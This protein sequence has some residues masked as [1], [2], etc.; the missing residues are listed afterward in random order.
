MSPRVFVGRP[1]VGWVADNSLPRIGRLLEEPH[2]RRVFAVDVSRQRVMPL[3]AGPGRQVAGPS[4]AHVFDGA[5]H[6][7]HG[8]LLAFGNTNGRGQW[9]LVRV[10]ED[11][12]IEDTGVPTDI[13]V[14]SLCCTDDEDLLLGVASTEIAGGQQIGGGIARFSLRTKVLTWLYRP[15]SGE[16]FVPSGI[17][18]DSGD[19]IFT[20][21]SKHTL[22]RLTSEGHLERVLGRVGRPD[23]DVGSLNSPTGV[24]VSDG[25]YVLTDRGNHRVLLVDRAGDVVGL[26]GDAAKD[27]RL[28]DPRHALS[29][30]SRVYIADLG[31]RAVL[32]VSADLRTTRERWGGPEAAGLVLSRPRSIDRAPTGELIV[33]DTNNDRIVGV[34]D[35][36]SL[37]WQI[38]RVKGLDGQTDDLRWPRSARISGS[39][40]LVVADGLNSR[41]LV[42]D[43]N[44]TVE[45]KFSRVLLKDDSFVVSD[46][47]DARWIGEDELLL[48]DSAAAW[49]ARVRGDG[50][51]VWVVAGLSDPHQADVFGEWVVIVDPE[52]DTVLL[53]EAVSG[54]EVWRRSEFYDSVGNL[55]RI[56]KPRVV[57]AAADC[58]LIVDADC[59]VVALGQDWSVRWTWNGK[60]VRPHG[61]RENFDIPDAPRDVVVDSMDRILL[62]DYRRNCVLELKAPD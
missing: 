54:A 55:Y 39:G 27:Q 31:T 52:I 47:H 56:F 50:V 2:S 61:H 40:R 44:G 37:R 32:E 20:R 42:L 30:H 26:F 48:V 35:R 58:V 34:D 53:V 41:F 4:G 45:H 7:K 23:S 43:R 9:A 18:W 49:V 11:G 15:P 14:M 51:A 22:M 36:G 28:I 3:G 1:I 57:R 8:L 62:S 25:H 10:R 21:T 59:Q 24:C 5:W 19:V 13:A 29:S 6:P 16:H 46:P 17:C 12:S 60:A 33:A 38:R